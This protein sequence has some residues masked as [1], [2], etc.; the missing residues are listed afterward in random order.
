MT[1]EKQSYLDIT[2]I[3]FYKVMSN[4]AKYLSNFTYKN[5]LHGHNLNIHII[6]DNSDSSL[7]ND[8]D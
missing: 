2:I 1:I 5:V 4:S 7:P 3:T 8:E 6:T